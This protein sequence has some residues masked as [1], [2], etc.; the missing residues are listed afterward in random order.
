VP[1]VFLLGAGFSKAVSDSMPDMAELSKALRKRVELPHYVTA[2][3]DNVEHWMTYLSQPQPWISQADNLH[4]KAMF[5]TLTQEIGTLL[6]EQISKALSSK[7]PDWL[8]ILVSWWHSNQ[9]NIITLNYDTLIERALCFTP[10]G[11]N[12]DLR[13]IYPV[14][15]PDIRRSMVF[16]PDVVKSFTLFKLHG[17]INWYYSGASE[18]YGETI[19]SAPVSQWWGQET[20]MEATAIDDA[21][22]AASDKVPLIIPPTTEKV[23][24]FQHE[25]VRQIWAQAAEALAYASHFYCIGYSLPETDLSLRFFLRNQAWT[26]N[27]PLTIVNNNPNAVEHYHTLL[28]DCYK[29]VDH[30]IGDKAVEKLVTDLT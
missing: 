20:S 10:T 29:M 9:A 22:N 23:A 11:G 14:A 16:A 13:N 15:L 12:F 24:Y 6:N 7:C 5:L 8:Q 21:R 25:T 19:Y 30:Y 17:S 2:L 4:H 3:G 1:D 27:L 18:Y 28:G 26:G